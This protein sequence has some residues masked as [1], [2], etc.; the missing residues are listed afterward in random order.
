MRRLDQDILKFKL[1]LEADNSGITEIIEKSIY[2]H[3]LELRS[4]VQMI[5]DFH[6]T[7]RAGRTRGNISI[8]SYCYVSTSQYE[9]TIVST[10]RRSNQ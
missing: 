8:D 9:K 10:L 3:E 4:C 5:L 2:R 6:D 1:E 7:S